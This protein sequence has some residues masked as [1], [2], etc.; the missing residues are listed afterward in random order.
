MIRRF[1]TFALAMVLLLSLWGCGAEKTAA[2][3]EVAYTV[4]VQ[5]ENG[6]PMAGVMV[7]LCKDVC[8]PGMTDAEGKAVITAAEDDYKVSILSLPEGYDYAGEETEF[9]FAAG[10]REITLTLKPVS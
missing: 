9:S 5:D 10:S 2:S 4:H 6:A 1:L 8:L 3:G 7:Q